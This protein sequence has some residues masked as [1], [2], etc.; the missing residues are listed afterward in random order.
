[1]LKQYLN[2]FVLSRLLYALES[3]MVMQ[4]QKEAL[5]VF[6]KN[7]L[8]RVQAL[9]QRTVNEAPYLLFR[10]LPAE[11]LHDINILNFFRKLAIDSSSILF[12]ICRCQLALKSLSSNLWFMVVAKHN[13]SK[14]GLPSVHTV[15]QGA[16]TL[17]VVKVETAGHQ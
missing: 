7:I 14:Y 3:L 12:H 9:P 8:K 5:D 1:M 11:A 17:K 13:I 4:K 2:A 6:L 15:L 10:I 16:S